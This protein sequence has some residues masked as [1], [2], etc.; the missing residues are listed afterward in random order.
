MTDEQLVLLI[1]ILDKLGY[2]AEAAGSG[3]VFQR[4]AQIAGYTDQVEG[5]VDTLETNLGTTGDAANAAGTVLARL[6]EL[7]TNRLT[8]ARAAKLDYLDGAISTIINRIPS[9]LAPG[10]GDLIL[11]SPIQN[12]WYTVVN[13][14]GAGVLT[15]L[16]VNDQYGNNYVQVRITRDGVVYNWD[17]ASVNNARSGPGTITVHMDFALRFNTSLLVEILN[18]GVATYMNAAVDYATV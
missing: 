11:S 15:N 7:L 18:S 14:S 3:T 1:D 6:A 2:S 13:I 4:L 12:Q 16:R 10:W 17:I 8:A 5:Y 9:G